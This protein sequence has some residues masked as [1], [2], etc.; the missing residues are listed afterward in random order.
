M[1]VAK[2]LS[3]ELHE[4]WHK[5]RMVALAPGFPEDATVFTASYGSM[6]LFLRSR[7]RGFGWSNSRTGMLGYKV[8]DFEIKL[9]RTDAVTANLH[10][11]DRG[12]GLNDQIV[13][14]DGGNWAENG[15]QMGDEIM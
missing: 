6:N 4:A 14:F 5:S 3:M 1:R 10:F 13:R 12:T 8:S 9:K 15:F 7:N 2:H 11:V